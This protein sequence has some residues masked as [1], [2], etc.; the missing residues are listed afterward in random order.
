M[1]TTL[2]LIL[3]V[4]LLAALAPPGAAAQTEEQTKTYIAGGWYGTHRSNDVHVGVLKFNV[5][6]GDTI[7]IDI[8][9]VGGHTVA[10]YVSFHEDGDARGSLTGTADGSVGTT[11]V[12]HAAN[13]EVPDDATHMR[14]ILN[15]PETQDNLPCHPQTATW[16]TVT[17]DSAA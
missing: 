10:A 15:S 5:E 16:G 11:E 13:L 2:T 14:V 4:A 1:R 17:V 12:C 3:S 9:D 6:P 7:T 8:R